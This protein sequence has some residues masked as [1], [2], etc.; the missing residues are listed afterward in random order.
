LARAGQGQLYRHLQGR[1]SARGDERTGHSR[2]VRR[3]VLLALRD[4]VSTKH[5]GR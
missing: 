5:T 3:R 1:A 4:Q 2:A